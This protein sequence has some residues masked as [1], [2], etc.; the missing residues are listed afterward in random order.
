MTADGDM[1]SMVI[2]IV[3]PI[4][5]IMFLIITMMRMM[6]M[7]EVMMLEAPICER[8]SQILDMTISKPRF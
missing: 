6:N 2:I 1:I 5:I 4:F 3:I 7:M 8:V